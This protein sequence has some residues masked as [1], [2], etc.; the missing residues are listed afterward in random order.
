MR[1]IRDTNPDRFIQLTNGPWAGDKAR[2]TL[3]AI[4]RGLRTERV[5]AV[6][7]SVARLR[8]YCKAEFPDTPVFG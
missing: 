4:E 2:A 1:A 7:A 8:S 6:N 3:H 5:V